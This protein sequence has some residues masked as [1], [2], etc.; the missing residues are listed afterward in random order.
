MHLLSRL[1]WPPSAF[2]AALPQEW[3]ECGPESLRGQDGTPRDEVRSLVSL[4][5]GRTEGVAGVAD[6][7]LARAIAQY[8]IS[9]ARAFGASSLPPLPPA[10]SPSSC[11]PCPLPPSP[12]DHVTGSKNFEQQGYFDVRQPVFNTL[13]ADQ[14]AAAVSRMAQLARVQ[15][16]VASPRTP[17]VLEA[18][19]AAEEPRPSLG[20]KLLMKFKEVAKLAAV[21]AKE[22][23]GQLGATAVKGQAGWGVGTGGGEVP[24]AEVS[25]VVAS[26]EHRFGPL[27]EM[28]PE[29]FHFGQGAARACAPFTATLVAVEPTWVIMIPAPAVRQAARRIYAFPAAS[30]TDALQALLARQP[31]A[32]TQWDVNRIA[33]HLSGHPLFA[34]LPPSVLP[35]LA[36]ALR[37]ASVPPG[38]V[39]FRQGARAQAGVHVVLTGSVS[40]HSRPSAAAPVASSYSTSYPGAGV[41]APALGTAPLEQ[42]G[43]DRASTEFLGRVMTQC[44]PGDCFGEAALACAEPRLCSAVAWES[45][46]VAEL[47]RDVFERCA[48]QSEAAQ[49]L[50]KLRAAICTALQEAPYKLSRPE[51]TVKLLQSSTARLAAFRDLAAIEP[52]M[53]LEMARAGELLSL[54]HGHVLAHQGSPQEELWWLL[55]GTV[56]AHTVDP[57]SVLDGAAPAGAGFGCM[58]RPICHRLSLG[59]V[60]F[61]LTAGDTIGNKAFAGLAQHMA[62][63]ELA[64]AEQVPEQT[65]MHANSL[66]VLSPT[67]QLVRFR[68][69]EYSDALLRL[70][71]TDLE[72]RVAALR[73][74]ASLAA[75]DDDALRGLAR[76]LRPCRLPAGFMMASAGAA[77]TTVYLLRDGMCVRLAQH[78]HDHSPALLPAPPATPRP[79]GTPRQL[80]AT[81][82]ALDLEARDSL[83]TGQGL[84]VGRGEVCFPL[85]FFLFN[86]NYFE[87]LMRTPLPPLSRLQLVGDLAA[88]LGLPQSGSVRCGT[89]ARTERG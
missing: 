79:A 3:K 77:V 37:A 74:S 68:R 42:V 31:E 28:L 55:S 8:Q 86:V 47:P 88:M 83:A 81:A 38:G 48:G 12:S 76:A 71:D 40:L 59:P 21:A 16:T 45:T 22:V 23:A 49:E 43:S 29:S 54:E 52:R 13:V 4:A 15:A 5:A 27:R 65:E 62:G 17:R 64:L 26:A 6:S 11:L 36:A 44:Y 24:H 56:A 33:E 53:H 66:V 89:E 84:A 7:T 73:R 25:A 69:A 2:Y 82:V 14:K 70:R 46:V 63:G 78:P 18:A 34:R 39:V 35:H 80:P 1:L 50:A 87:L 61:L 9:Q 72:A 41:T 30:E 20:G 75:W 60:H 32:R 19:D 85:S 67:A 51:A 58:L 57:A 10:S